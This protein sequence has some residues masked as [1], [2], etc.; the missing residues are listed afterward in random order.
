M[1][2]YLTAC[3]ASLALAIASGCATN[4]SRGDDRAARQSVAAATFGNQPYLFAYFPARGGLSDALKAAAP[5]ASPGASQDIDSLVS[6]MKRGEAEATRIAVSGGRDEKTAAILG[7]ALTRL[8]GQR[9]PLLEVVFVGDPS[10]REKLEPAVTAL[11]AKFA[12]G[13]YR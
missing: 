8:K 9:L 12:L 6:M 4:S 1:N 13:E 3:I 7:A 5:E 10:Y 2:R 11:G